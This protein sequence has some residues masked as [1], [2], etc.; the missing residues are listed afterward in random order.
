MSFRE[1]DRDIVRGS[2]YKVIKFNDKVFVNVSI[3][4]YFARHTTGIKS[5]ELLYLCA[6]AEKNAKPITAEMLNKFKTE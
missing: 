5:P 2:Q 1:I 4:K 6:V 3:L